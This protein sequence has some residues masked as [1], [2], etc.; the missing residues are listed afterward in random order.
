MAL[1]RLLVTVYGAVIG[2]VRA[3]PIGRVVVLHDEVS[4]SCSV[5]Q[6]VGRHASKRGREHTVSRPFTALAGQKTKM[7]ERLVFLSLG[8]VKKTET[9]AASF[10]F[11][12]VNV[13]AILQEVFAEGHVLIKIRATAKDGVG[14]QPNPDGLLV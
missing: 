9:L 13:R 8:P 7:R 6:V 14:F 4:R 5:W 12:V 10:N 1:Y 2:A 3:M 11:F